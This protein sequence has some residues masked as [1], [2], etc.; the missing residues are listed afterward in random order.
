MVNVDDA[1]RITAGKVVGENLHV[2]GEDQKIRFVLV[3][4]LLDTRLGLVLVVFRDL[5]DS[6]RS[7]VE[8]GDGLI[9]GVVG[10]DQRNVA[11][12]FAAAMPVEK[13]D[14]AMVVFRDEN[15]HARAVRRL[16]Q[17]PLHGEGLSYGREMLCEIGEILL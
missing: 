4:Q 7:L 12:Q 9:V 8:V 16:C 13:I 15:D 6:V 2:A 11:S 10:D 3:E 14:Q 5:N 1:L 17:T